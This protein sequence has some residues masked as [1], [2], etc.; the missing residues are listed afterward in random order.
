MT[1]SFQS[2]ME[3]KFKYLWGLYLLSSAQQF[4]RAGAARG[5]E[6]GWEHDLTILMQASYIYWTY[7]I[8]IDT[9]YIKAQDYAACF[10]LHEENYCV[11]FC[12]CSQLTDSLSG[13]QT[14][15]H[16]VSEKEVYISV[17]KSQ[18]GGH[19]TILLCRWLYWPSG[20]A[21]PQG[22]Y[23]RA[24][25]CKPIILFLWTIFKVFI[26]FVTILLLF[27]ALVFWPWGMWDLC[28][29]AR[30]QTHTSCLGRQSLNH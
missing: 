8:K 26:E 21:I 28:S 12:P 10:N 7:H 20:V 5:G 19:Q 14:E 29:P 30:D 18:P 25:N 17:T 1:V 9:H 15:T 2:V 13:Q 4:L 11:R 23:A 3:V 27:Y 22:L 24:L 16:A 6:A